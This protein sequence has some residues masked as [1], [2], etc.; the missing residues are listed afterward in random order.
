MKFLVA[1]FVFSLFGLCIALPSNTDG[2]SLTERKIPRDCGKFKFKCNKA[3]GACNNAC[4][5]INCVNKGNN[6]FI[7]GK[8]KVDNRVHSG[9]TT[10][11]SSTI[12]KLSPFGQRM[13]DRQSDNLAAKPLQCDEFPMNAFQQREFKEGTIR[14]SLRCVNGGENGSEYF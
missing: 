13:W 1:L 4:Y 8:S 7:Y 9:C 10:S 3:A 6:R 12:C 5:F 11:I 2:T 14:N